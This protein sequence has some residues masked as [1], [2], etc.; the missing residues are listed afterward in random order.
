MSHIIYLLDNLHTSYFCV[1]NNVY[2]LPFSLNFYITVHSRCLS[3]CLSGYKMNEFNW[4]KYLESCNAQA[5]PK[6][7][8]K[9][10]TS[11]SALPWA[12]SA[13]ISHTDSRR[14]KCLLAVNS[15]SY[16]LKEPVIL[17]SRKKRL[18]WK[19]QGFICIGN[20]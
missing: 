16:R 9:S 15:A 5:A 20:H 8:F 19:Y 17:Y 10:Q 11:V 13:D 4:E 2:L 3:L 1:L 7:L 12:D 6:N 18:Q 14:R